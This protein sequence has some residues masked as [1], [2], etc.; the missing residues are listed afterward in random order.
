MAVDSKQVEDVAY[1]VA[2]RVPGVEVN[3]YVGGHEAQLLDEPPGVRPVP[4]DL[5]QLPLQRRREEGDLDHRRDQESTD[6]G[7]VC[8]L[9]DPEGGGG[10]L[11]PLTAVGRTA[12]PEFAGDEPVAVRIRLPL[13]PGADPW[14]LDELRGQAPVEPPRG[15]GVDRRSNPLHREVEGS[16]VQPRDGLGRYRAP[17]VVLHERYGFD[18][19]LVHERSHARR[20]VDTVEVRNRRTLELAGS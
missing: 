20:E 11:E 13:E 1:V 14:V 16:P 3:A 4:V 18:R 12:E 7:Q 5:A 10:V 9:R 6:R 15:V 8:P 2:H 17:V 19:R